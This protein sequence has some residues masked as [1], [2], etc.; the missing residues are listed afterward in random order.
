ME[1][2]RDGLVL[3]GIDRPWLQHWLSRQHPTQLFIFTRF[4]P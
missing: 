2:T 1:K 4:L 3:R